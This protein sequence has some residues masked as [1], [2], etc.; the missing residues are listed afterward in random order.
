MHYESARTTRRVRTAHGAR[1]HGAIY[2]RRSPGGARRIAHGAW[3]DSALKAHSARRT[4]YWRIGDSF[5]ITA[6]MNGV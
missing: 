1:I 3:R 5:F 2:E 6:S 4:S